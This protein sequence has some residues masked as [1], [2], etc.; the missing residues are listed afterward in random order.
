MAWT[1]FPKPASGFAASQYSPPRPPESL[2][3]PRR[4]S[5]CKPLCR[6]PATIICSSFAGVLAA[7]S[8]GRLPRPAVL[9]VLLSL[10]ELG[11]SV[12]YGYQLRNRPGSFLNQLSAD[13]DLAAWLRQAPGP[14]RVQ[15]DEEQIPYNFGDWYG[16]DVFGGYL[17]S[18]SINVDSV[19]GFDR[20]RNLMGVNY[21]V[22]RTPRGDGQ[23][24]VFRAPNGLNVYRNNDAFPPV[25]TVHKVASIDPRAM[26][27]A[28]DRGGAR[29]REEAFFTGAA[30]PTV[31]SC[32]GDAV[33]LLRREANSLEIEARMQCRGVVVAGE[34]DDDGWRAWIDGTPTPL[35]QAYGTARAVV[36]PAGHH[37][38]LMRYL[39]ASVVAGAIL[40]T[41]G[42]AVMLGLFFL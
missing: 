32:S 18:L 5:L 34:N 39:P 30:P 21:W 9:L 41:I 16:I 38:I 26:G 23:R 17:A 29:L 33:A 3:L 37:R 35:Y 25:W 14:V 4:G 13:R 12:G 7:W 19:R 20:A 22:G 2:T 1:D 27:Q 15:M 40:S 28:F 8:A 6:E 11:T 42:F 31:E 10:L 24:E 36:V